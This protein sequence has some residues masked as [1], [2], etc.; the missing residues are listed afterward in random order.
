MK[1][2][3]I[4]QQAVI[5][6]LLSNFSYSQDWV[7]QSVP[8]TS[9]YFLDMKFANANTGYI[10]NSTP[11]FLKTTDSGFNWQT[12]NNFNIT[13]LAVIDSMYVYG[14]GHTAGYSKLYKST[15]SGITWDSLLQNSPYFASLYFFN[16]DTGLISGYDGF[17]V[18]I[19]R[20]TNGGQTAVQVYTI[21]S[22]H[23]TKF[24]FV[25]KK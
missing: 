25:K 18:F 20:T 17:N 11:L 15:D 12:V 14:A 5:I 3:T 4:L 21:N 23:F 22:S 8:F 7:Q 6:L 19:G 1:I 9:G 13:S 2:Y 10:C 24:F 16:R